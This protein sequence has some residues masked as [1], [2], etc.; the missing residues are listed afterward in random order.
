MTEPAFFFFNKCS[1]TS[2]FGL[3]QWRHCI[4]K[5]WRQKAISISIKPWEIVYLY[6]REKAVLASEA[7]EVTETT[8]FQRHKFQFL[9]LYI[10]IWKKKGH[11]CFISVHVKRLLAALSLI[12]Q[13]LMVILTSWMFLTGLHYYIS[14]SIVIEIPVSSAWCVNVIQISFYSKKKKKQYYLSVI[15]A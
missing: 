8:E 1:V 2:S 6:I 3:N 7:N 12:A 9:F 14:S 10:L 5:V 11:L 15:C 4:R 13:F